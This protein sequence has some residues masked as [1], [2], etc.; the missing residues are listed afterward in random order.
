VACLGPEYEALSIV[1]RSRDS[2]ISYEELAH[3]LTNHELYL[4]QTDKKQPPTPI[5]AQVAQRT[6][7]HNN[8]SNRQTRRWSGQPQ[9]HSQTTPSGTQQWRTPHTQSNGKFSQSWRL[10]IPLQAKM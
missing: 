9:W 3:K 6:N 7:N 2:H 1:I 4:K 8:N 5:T 10:S